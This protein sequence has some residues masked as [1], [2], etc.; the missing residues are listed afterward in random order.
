MAYRAVYR[1]NLNVYF[2]GDK[3]CLW[4]ELVAEFVDMSVICI[5]IGV[6]YYKQKAVQYKKYKSK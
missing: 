2:V 1:S 5:R 4:C 3:L 6:D